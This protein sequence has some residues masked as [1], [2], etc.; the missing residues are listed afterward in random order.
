MSES[1][2]LKCCE[3]SGRGVN[4]REALTSTLKDERTNEREEPRETFLHLID[5]TWRMREPM[6][7]SQGRPSCI[8]QAQMWKVCPL[9]VLG[10]HEINCL[11]RNIWFTASHCLEKPF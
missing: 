4:G 3:G 8:S 10:P 2:M 9:T 6:R 7:R 11:Q 5:Q 1:E